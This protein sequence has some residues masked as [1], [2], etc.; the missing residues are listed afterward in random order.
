MKT[1]KFKILLIGLALLSNSCWEE[2]KKL[3]D[4]IQN[5]TKIIKNA[6]NVAK[7]AT[8]MQE[9]IKLLR[10]KEPLTKEQFESWLPE[11]LANMPLTSSM[12]NMIPGMGSCGGTY[13][14]GNKRIR[15]MVIDGAGEKG[16]GGVGPYRMSS[17]MN[18]DTKGDWGSTKTVL[19][20]DVKVKKSYLKSSN[21]YDLSMF[22][23]E[24]FAVDIKTNEIDEVTLEKIVKELNLSELKKF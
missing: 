7:E 22:Y 14:V 21:S 15:V 19:I 20:D 4:E 11:T 23:A 17:K 18:Y 10:N 13:H 8:G 6:K 12:I 5:T 2:T 24:R 16:A 1:I 3:G 9:N